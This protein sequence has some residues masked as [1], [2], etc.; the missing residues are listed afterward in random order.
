[1]ECM[2][3]HVCVCVCVCLC[4]FHSNKT[5][6]LQEFTTLEILFLVHCL[7]T[8]WKWTK[9]SKGLCTFACKQV[10][11]QGV[12]TSWKLHVCLLC[13]CVCGHTCVLLM[14]TN[15]NIAVCCVCA[16][17]VIKPYNN[18]IAC[19]VMSL[20]MLFYYYIKSWYSRLC[21]GVYTLAHN[22]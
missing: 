8:A 15:K 1:M 18:N 19:T 17:H 9:I 7:C 22:V 5:L 16:V 6:S 21:A 14:C 20:Q 10:Y 12:Y 2:C 3:V 13:L 11:F 4:V